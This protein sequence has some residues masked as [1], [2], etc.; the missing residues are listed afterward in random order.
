M[1]DPNVQLIQAGTSVAVLQGSPQHGAW[2]EWYP[3]GQ[4]SI[5]NFDFAA[6]DVIQCTIDVTGR[7]DEGF[8]NEVNVTWSNVTTGKSV[9][10]PQSRPEKF[11]GYPCTIPAPGFTANW[12]L[13]LVQPPP[14]SKLPDPVL[15]QFGSVYYDGC[16][17]LTGG[18]ETALNAG[19]GNLVTM[20]GSR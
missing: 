2:F 11:E 9:T 12:I 10:G 6:G 19:Q 14:G 1:N 20:V 3:A 17:A 16:W 4:K 5:A 8:I 18:P 13:E 15:A 7:D